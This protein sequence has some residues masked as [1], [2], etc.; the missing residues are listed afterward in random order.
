MRLSKGFKTSDI[1]QQL[2]LSKRTV[3]TYY[4]RIQEKY[5]IRGL[6]TLR[7]IAKE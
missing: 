3:E 1:L 2:S 5:G 6:E 7:N 4:E